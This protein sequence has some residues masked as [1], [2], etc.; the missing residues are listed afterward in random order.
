MT[1]L[2]NHQV[3]HIVGRAKSQL[4]KATFCTAAAQESNQILHPAANRF[5]NHRA[6]QQVQ[7]PAAVQQKETPFLEPLSWRFPEEPTKDE[8]RF[9][10]NF[11]LRTP[12]AP[13]SIKVICGDNSIRVE[14]KRDLLGTG[15]LV[16]TTDVTLG[17]CA[18]TEEDPKAQILIFESELHGCGSQLLMSEE[19]F[20][21]VFTLLYT[22]SPPGGSPI[23]RTIDV[24]VSIECHYR[25]KND[26]S[27]DVLKPTWAPFSETKASEESLY[28]SLRLMT[29]DWQF[30]RSSTQFFLGDM[31]KF[32]ASV[33]QFHHIPLRVTV[34]SCVA[35]VVPNVDTVPRYAFLGNNGCMFDS[36]LTG[37]SSHFLPQSHK[38]KLQFELEAFRFQHGNSGVIY[39]TC[40]LRATDAAANV[41]ATNKA[42]SFS[43]G[44]REASGIHHA[45]SCCDTD[46]RAGT[47]SSLTVKGTKW[48]QE[49]A[50][51]PITVKEKPL[52]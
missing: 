31:M 24:S 45:C 29:D 51:G 6:N 40:S 5:G 52:R 30:P 37:S 41:N 48:E 4:Y 16:Q 47:K 13:E 22:P 38:D 14:A 12:M 32:E 21:Y 44:W 49:M 9:P 11:E 23:V 35:T 42:C 26:V 15:V 25:R 3:N 27:S 8:P 33:E 34:D 50:V 36:Q 28:F 2:Q 1:Q 19:S 46:C 39:I 43:S 7:R 17:G 10:P 20:I 18:A